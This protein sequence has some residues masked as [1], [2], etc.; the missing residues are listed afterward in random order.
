MKHEEKFGVALMVVALLLALLALSISENWAPRLD[1]LQNLMLTLKIRL[2]PE[3]DDPYALAMI[4]V[5]TK[6]VLLGLVAVA[7]YGFTTYLGI[8]P[9]WK[10]SEAYPATPS[11]PA[12]PP[13][14]A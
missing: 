5:Y 10:K 14:K 8:T 11:K 7:A 1:A 9:A 2:L 3:S 12:E 6:H 4:D 13:K